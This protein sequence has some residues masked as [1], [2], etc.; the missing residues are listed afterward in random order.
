MA[1][2]AANGAATTAA[3]SDAVT[4]VIAVSV[5]LVTSQALIGSGGSG[6]AL[7]AAGK[8]EAR[9]SQVASVSASARGSSSGGGRGGRVLGGGHGRGPHHPGD[10]G[11]ATWLAGGDVLFEAIGASAASSTAVASAAGAAAE[12]DESRTDADGSGADR[13]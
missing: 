6:G 3:G 12:D 9:A 5:S 7:A 1:T 8:I 13:G 2:E 11:R 10:L 4:P